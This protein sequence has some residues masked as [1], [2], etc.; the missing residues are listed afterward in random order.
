MIKSGISAF[1]VCAIFAS[2]A[3]AEPARSYDIAAQALGPALEAFAAVSGRE[4]VAQSD[5]LTGKRSEPVSGSLSPETAVARLLA[6]T[7]LTW[8][9]VDGAFVI[10]EASAAPFPEGEAGGDAGIVVTGTR[11]RG[12]AIASPKITVALEAMKDQGLAT[13]TEA[14][15][16]IPQNFG[17]GQNPGVGFAV[18]VASGLNVSGG[19]SLNL[20][21]LGS[22]ATLTLLNGRRLAYSASRQSIDLSAIPAGIVERIE[23]V[24]DGASAIY[25]SDAVAG[26]ANIILRRDREGL[27]TTARLGGSTDGGND[28]QTYSASAGTRWTGGGGIV[29]YEYGSN[30]AIVGRQRDYTATLARGLDL[31]P[32]IVRHNAALSVHQEFGRFTA[33]LD[34]LYNRRRS[35]QIYA[36]NAAGNRALNRVEL[37]S[38]TESF[39]IAPALR[40]ELG[41]GWRAELSGGYGEDKV[42][43]ESNVFSGATQASALVGCFC[44]DLKSVELSGDGPL[45]ELPAGAA[46]LALGVG[47]RDVGFVSFRGVGS[48][49]NIAEHQRSA[50]AFGEASLLLLARADGTAALRAT[51][52]LRYER[53]ADIEDVVTP[54]LGLVVSPTA[55]FD[56]KAS[57][58]RSFRAPTFLQRYSAVIAVLQPAA[59]FGGSGLPA[60]STGLSLIGG[61]EDLKP[62]RARSWSVTADIHPRGLA[63]TRLELSYFDIRYT[64]RIVAPI[65]F[66]RQALTNPIYADQVTRSPSAALL[67]QALANAAQ[68][69]NVTGAAYD[70][71]KV[72]AIVDNTNINAAR[73]HIRGVDAA[74]SFERAVGGGPARITAMLNASYLK[75]SQ[76]LTSA[77]PRMQLAGLLFNPP[78]FRARGVLGWNDGPFALTGAV[79]RIGGVTDP[80]AV[81]PVRVDGMTTFDLTA[82]IR[83]TE[84]ARLLAGLE[85]ILSGQNLFNAKPDRIAQQLTYD[86]TYDS[87]N[88]SPVGRFVS[89]SLSKTW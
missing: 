82:R 40:A 27:V 60:G 24:A 13:T 57:W 52:A 28:Q 41:G 85:L 32:E 58:G 78:H 79:N 71:A 74:L 21:G 55:D 65:A 84:T 73:Q 9:V 80:R 44:N 42:R 49:Q 69:F 15:Q 3:R 12:A 4:V 23:I 10:R 46:R 47:Y 50:Y 18:P 5:I 14:A 66:N 45:F 36:I 35:L 1:A 20:R 16:S 88:Y 72:V 7:G 77:Q 53:Y 64:D 31:F 33:S 11:I 86:H 59:S 48:P 39:L 87:T 63:G 76:Q 25:G 2:P 22:D 68:F 8:S 26:V 89:V 43:Y 62:E 67:A 29:A 30:T 38:R 54:K 83:S 70:P 17:G 56:L 51:G 75:S 34:A 6:G 37:P 19:T 81:T 61:R